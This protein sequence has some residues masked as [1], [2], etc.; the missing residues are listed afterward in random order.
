MPSGAACDGRAP[1]L[2]EPALWHPHR[3]G[4]NNGRQS[5]QRS[6]KALELGKNAERKCGI[7]QRTVAGVLASA[8]SFFIRSSPPITIRQSPARIMESSEGLKIN[9]PSTVLI[10][11]T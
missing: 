6:R 3:Q 10:A 11:K 1:D 2:F 5:A 4:A 9:L 8:S 7:G